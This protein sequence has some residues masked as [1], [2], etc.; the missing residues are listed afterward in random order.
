MFCFWVKRGINCSEVMFYLMQ[1][2]QKNWFTILKRL[3]CLITDD[4]WKEPI[5]FED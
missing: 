5:I 3:R 2:H 1:E 4:N